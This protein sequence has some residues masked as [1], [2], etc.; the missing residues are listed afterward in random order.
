MKDTF[1]FKHYTAT[2]NDAAIK[3]L[4]FKHGATGYGVYWMLVE[5]LYDN[6]NQL[7]FDCEMLAHDIRTTPEVVCSVIK[8][9]NLFVIEDGFVLSHGVQKQIDWRQKRSED[10]RKYAEKRWKDS[11]PNGYPMATQSQP[12]GN[13]STVE[14]STVQNNTKH[15]KDIPAWE[16]FHAYAL[17]KK[18]NID[19]SHLRLKYDS[20]VENGWQDGNGKQI[21]NW[22]SKLLNTI[23]HLKVTTVNKVAL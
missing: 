20:W 4:I 8:D 23:P 18:R 14:Y 22:K 15:N 17:T 12:N 5:M 19:E 7:E 13:N 6:D 11:K 21:K 2:K 1:Y 3:K 9:F 16:T 10:G